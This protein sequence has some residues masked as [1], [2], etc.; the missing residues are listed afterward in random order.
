MKIIVG[1]A[2]TH[3]RPRADDSWKCRRIGK[4]ALRKIIPRYGGGSGDGC[5]NGGKA[6]TFNPTQAV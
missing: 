3:I 4:T 5:R 2:T 1:T 6:V